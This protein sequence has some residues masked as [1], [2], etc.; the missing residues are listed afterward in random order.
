MNYV[1]A[2]STPLSKNAQTRILQKCTYLK[3]C[4]EEVLDIFPYKAGIKNDTCC[5]NVIRKLQVYSQ[6]LP[7]ITSSRILQNGL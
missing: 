5:Q 2:E 4:L 3:L 6:P 1:H 7:H